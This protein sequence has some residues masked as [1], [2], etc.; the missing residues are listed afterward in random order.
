[1][2]FPGDPSPQ[3]TL[4]SPAF[5]PDSEYINQLNSQLI[6]PISPMSLNSITTSPPGEFLLSP[7]YC[8][9]T[10]AKKIFTVTKVGETAFQ[11]SPTSGSLPTSSPGLMSPA[12]SMD[13]II[14]NF[15]TDQ[16]SSGK[17]YSNPLSGPSEIRKE[18]AAETVSGL[19]G[20]L[21]ETETIQTAQMPDYNFQNNKSAN[22]CQ[23]QPD[24]Q[25]DNANT[26]NQEVKLENTTNNKTSLKQEICLSESK[27]DNENSNK[28]L[29]QCPSND[30]SQINNCNDTPCLVEFTEDVTR[31]TSLAIN[32]NT[33]DVEFVN[34]RN[35]D[36]CKKDFDN[37]TTG[38]LNNEMDAES[39]VGD[40]TAESLLTKCDKEI[41][42]S[43]HNASGIDVWDESLEMSKLSFN[44]YCMNF[45]FS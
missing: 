1:M 4:D 16:A 18:I 33:N 25:L 5:I 11:R 15:G 29:V 34:T 17:V 13:Q 14:L 42:H 35:V 39:F 26:E 3:H 21:S 20:I 12:S 45:V 41:D 37:V 30:C 32:L 7:Q 38:K 6:S 8:E 28:H 23:K 40:I 31:D 2:L 9:K 43:T 44:I 10:K 19:F 24:Q 27:N 22:E 36:N